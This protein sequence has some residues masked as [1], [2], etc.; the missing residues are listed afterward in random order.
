MPDEYGQV[1]KYE[2]WIHIWIGCNKS[3]RIIVFHKVLHILLDI[4]VCSACRPTVLL[5]RSTV[6]T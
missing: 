2:T 3:R 1:I 6:R 5:S 4:A